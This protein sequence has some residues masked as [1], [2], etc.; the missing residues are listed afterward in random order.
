MSFG[1]TNRFSP[2]P[3]R[4]KESEIVRYGQIQSEIA[5][6]IKKQPEVA[7]N[8][9]KQSERA[10]KSQKS[11]TQPEIAR[12]SQKQPEIARNSQEWP[13]IARYSQKSQTQP[14]RVRNSQEWPDITRNRSLEVIDQIYQIDWIAWIRSSIGR[15]SSQLYVDAWDGIGWMELDGY[16]RSSQSKSTLAAYDINTKP[17][18]KT[19][20]QQF[21]IPSAHSSQNKVYHYISTSKSFLHKLNTRYTLFALQWHNSIGFGEN[22]LLQEYF[23][24]IYLND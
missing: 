16:H 24:I 23:L 11:H 21:Q 5:K 22:T 10:R 17:S 4:Q 8:S 12:N 19:P 15:V 3:A 18:D 20:P 14:E 1:V 6:N 9:Q 7:R 13:E 2:F